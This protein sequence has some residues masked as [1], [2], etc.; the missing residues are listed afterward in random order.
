MKYEWEAKI[1]KHIGAMQDL[2]PDNFQIVAVAIEA[3]DEAEGALVEAN[4]VDAKFADVAEA[5]IRQDILG[6]ARD[7]YKRV[8]DAVFADTPTAQ[9][10]KT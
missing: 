5:D 9:E 6:D 7:Q 1:K 3:V 10:Q 4:C 2:L 8:L